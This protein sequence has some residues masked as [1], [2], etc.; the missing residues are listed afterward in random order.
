M[1]FG[2]MG[3]I[4]F[5]NLTNKKVWS[6]TVEQHVYDN[7][8]SG[9]GLGAYVLYNRVPK[10]ADPL[11]P[12]NILGFVS[13]FLTATGTLFTGQWMVVSKSPL[14]GGFGDAICGG[15]F[16]KAIK[17][18]GYDG[19]FILG[20]SDHPVYIDINDGNV[21]IRDAGHIWGRDSVESENLLR[22]LTQERK[23]HVAVIGQA[24][25]N[26]SLISGICHD[27]GRMASRSGLGAVMGSKKLK[28]LVIS[29]TKTTS[30]NDKE[31]IKK[32]SQSVIPFMKKKYPINLNGNMLPY[33]GRFIRY[34]PFQYSIDGAF[35]KAGLKKWGT[36]FQTQL[37]LESGEAP[38]KN[39]KGTIENFNLVYSSTL[40]ADRFI[41][42]QIKPYYCSSCP[43]GCGGICSTKG[44]YQRTQKPE[45]GTVNALG[46]LILNNDLEK[47]FHWNE[48]L[49]RA[50]MDAISAGA[51]IAFA[52][53]CFEKGI[54]SLEDTDGLNLQWGEPSVIEILIE[55]M[56]NRE[57]F[58]GLLT[59]GVC[60]ASKQFGLSSH[61]FAIHAGGQELPMHDPRN[62][63]G[64]AIH[65]SA[66]PNPGQCPM[67]F[68]GA[69]ERYGLWQKIQTLPKPRSV[70]RKHEKYNVDKEK[71][72]CAAAC[73]DY[74]NLIKASGVCLNSINFGCS[75]IPVFQWLN[76][77]TGW[78]KTPENYMH[79]GRRIQHIKQA[80]N[81]RQDIA[82]RQFIMHSRASGRPPQTKGT[83]AGRTLHTEALMKAYWTVYGWDPETGIPET[84]VLKAFG[85]DAV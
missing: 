54:I 68:Q 28:A 59:D 84:S 38:I 34:L 50:G 36:L 45:Y 47:I 19:I 62:E 80:F 73:S 16:S 48:L 64:Y 8:L 76:A 56:I 1:S 13:G 7:Y 69:Y 30:V 85:I 70:Y 3:T 49:I 61:P 15:K 79:I 52:L 58:G 32:L 83:N 72:I 46:A 2:N 77:V 67:G 37:Y 40:N 6:E 21:D 75:I 4:L 82:P 11:G 33:I 41:E 25:E 66:E 5:I 27:Y 44:K 35:F 18:S 29:G 10:K 31:E 17:R 14:T 81:I 57:G 42:R 63:P 55:Q 51:T 43:L 53:E 24:G 23:A 78:Q 26:L 22:K 12:E 39:W 65:Y 74:M 9:L 71:A 60:E 20:Q